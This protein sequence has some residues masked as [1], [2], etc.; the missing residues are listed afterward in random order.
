MERFLQAVELTG[1][2]FSEA[3]KYCATSWLPARALVLADVRARHDVDPSGQILKLNSY[4]PWKE[5]LFQI[6]KEEGATGTIKYVIYEDDRE[7]KWRV[8]AVAVAPGSFESRRPLPVAWRGLRD[9]EL[10]N[11]TQIPGCVFVHASGF[12]GGNDTEDGALQMAKKA[13]EVN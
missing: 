13:L 3:V 2:E 4:C 8:Q 7:K 5:H 6:E 12:I 1:K 10:S 9:S 11:A